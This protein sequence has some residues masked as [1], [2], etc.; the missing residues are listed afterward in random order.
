MDGD[1]NIWD[2][3]DDGKCLLCK[4]AVVKCERSCKIT[5]YVPY[6]SPCS[7]DLPVFIRERLVWFF[8]S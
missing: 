5:T 3:K 6:L 4:D 2:E 7:R 1:T 8:G